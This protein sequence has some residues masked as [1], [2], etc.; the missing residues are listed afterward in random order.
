MNNKV[1]KS[2]DKSDLLR[3]AAI[4][5]YVSG[6]QTEVAKQNFE[7]LLENDYELRHAVDIEIALRGSV[8]EL[9]SQTPVEMSNFEDL[10]RSIESNEGSEELVHKEIFE[11]SETSTNG[12]FNVI[13]LFGKTKFKLAASFVMFGLLGVMF[14]SFIF[15]STAPKYQTLSNQE[16]SGEVDFGMLATQG[17]LAKFVLQD[18]LT[19]PQTVNLL[20][21]YSLTAF[22]AGSVKHEV[23]A[24][25]EQSI[26]D[27][28]IVLW[29]ADARI[30]HVDVF[31]AK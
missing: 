13:S 18:Q 6:G 4:F 20:L 30:V 1:N 10:L 29:R 3:D 7:K 31:S 22:E 17:R 19:E 15:D 28:D 14:A 9:N 26:S 24:Y 12:G 16:A 27:A 8:K 5:D 11:D 2:I 25:S 21:G 23:Y